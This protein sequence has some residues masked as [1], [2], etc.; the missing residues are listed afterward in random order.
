MGW[1]EEGVGSLRERKEEEAKLVRAAEISTETTTVAASGTN[2][3][4]AD[5]LSEKI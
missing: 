2:V 5:S 1:W 4:L 3:L